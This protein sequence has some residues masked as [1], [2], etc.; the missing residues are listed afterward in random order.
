MRY[1]LATAV[2]G[3][4]DRLGRVTAAVKMCSQGT[5]AAGAAAG[6]FLAGAAGPRTALFLLGAAS[7]AVT[8]LLLPAPVRQAGPG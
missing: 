2:S 4:R 6:G 3:T 7:L 8:V 5:V 1:W